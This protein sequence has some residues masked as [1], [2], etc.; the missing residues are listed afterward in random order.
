MPS[1]QSDLNVYLIKRA[2]IVDLNADPET[3]GDLFD[4]CPVHGVCASSQS[5]HQQQQSP[6]DNLSANMPNMQKTISSSWNTIKSTAGL[7]TNNASFN[8]NDEVL[9]MFNETDSFFYC[10]NGDLTNS[11]QRKNTAE[12]LELGRQEAPF[13]KRADDRFFFNR[14]LLTFLIDKSDGQPQLS[15][16]I[17]PIMQVGL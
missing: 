12:Y 10:E 8:L 16:F 5:E 14:H 13:W 1:D 4:N 9:R 17:V 3:L 11:L 15:N 2:A 7:M 6:I